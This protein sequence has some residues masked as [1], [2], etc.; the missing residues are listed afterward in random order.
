LAQIWKDQDAVLP[1]THLRERSAFVLPGNQEKMQWKFSLKPAILSCYELHLRRNYES[2][3]AC[4]SHSVKH[5]AEWEK[6]S[7]LFVSSSACR[8]IIVNTSNMKQQLNS[9]GS[10]ADSTGNSFPFVNFYWIRRRAS[11]PI[12]ETWHCDCHYLILVLCIQ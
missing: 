9:C 1:L 12:K 2:S 10:I 6:N 7:W 5:E 11:V 3:N 4:A 8:S